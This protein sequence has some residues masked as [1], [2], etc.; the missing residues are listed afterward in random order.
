M[1]DH[2]LLEIKSLK[3]FHDNTIDQVVNDTDR[4]LVSKDTLNR[5]CFVKTDNKCILKKSHDYYYQIQCQ[6]LVTEREFCD[7]VLYAKDGPISVQRIYRDQQL[8]CDILLRLSALW[9]RV[10]APEIIEMRVP[11]DLKP[12]V[13]SS[14]F[15]TVAPHNA[16]VSHGNSD[17]FDVSNDD[18]AGVSYGNS[19]EFDLSNDDI[20]N[21]SHG[22][23]N[24][25]DISNGDSDYVSHDNGDH[26]SGVSNLSGY[27]TD[28]INKAVLLTTCASSYHS[29]E[30]NLL[31]DCNFIV[32]P[33]SGITSDGIKL[34][35]TCPIDNWLMIF[36][37]LAKSGR[38][39][40]HNLN[41][42]GE[43]INVALQLI[44][45]NKFADAK[46]LF[47]QNPD[48]VN[49]VID[50]YGNEADYCIRVLL[51]FLATSLMSSCDQVACPSKTEMYKSHSISL[52]CDNNKASFHSSLSEWLHSQT[53]TCQRKFSSKPSSDTPCQSDQTQ[54]CDGT[55]SVSWH[56]AGIRTTY[57]RTFHCFKNF[58]IFSV[59][60]LSRRCKLQISDLPASIILNGQQLTLHSGTLWNGHHYIC[61][62]RHNNTWFV[63]DGL[64]EYNQKNSGLSVF[65]VLPKGYY[66]SHVLFIV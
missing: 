32:I 20:A 21:V 63:Y 53:T 33:W 3:I 56:C 17:E 66:L 12:F 14:S 15:L 55:T 34:V 44:D 19:D 59:D 11:R 35:N 45:L 50:C 5:Q 48:V 65:S 8:I 27:T 42:A 13:M 46:I 30:N 6:L 40:L 62:F 9:K 7:F 26:C 49:G 39:N 1:G 29:T 51:P 4:V 54:N 64:K 47:V 52:G 41:Q 31:S 43:L 16:N 61:F 58:A 22:N 24:E 60:L 38:L 18:I 23:G 2:G 10:I 36:Q 37:S 25:F 28:E 57:Q